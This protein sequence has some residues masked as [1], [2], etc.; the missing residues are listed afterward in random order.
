M[1]STPTVLAQTTASSSG[2]VSV[3]VTIPTTASGTHTMVML[4]ESPTG[5]QFVLSTTFTVAGA[6]GGNGGGG[7]GGGD[8][9]AATGSR[10]TLMT[11]LIAFVLLQLGLVVAVRSYRAMPARRES[12]LTASAPTRGSHRR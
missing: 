6:T 10:E 4:G 2:A 12:D 1:Y 8:E 11:A 7:G 9:L 3:D 5:E